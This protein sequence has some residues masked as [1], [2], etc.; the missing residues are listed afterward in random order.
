M[1]PWKSN[2]NGRDLLTNCDRDKRDATETSWGPKWVASLYTGKILPP[3]MASEKLLAS[4]VTDDCEPQ[5]NHPL[6]D[7]VVTLVPAGDM[8]PW[9]N[10][11]LV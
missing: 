4:S 7:L 1:E 3:H 10:R 2:T 9:S 5:P 6:L 11:F 8:L